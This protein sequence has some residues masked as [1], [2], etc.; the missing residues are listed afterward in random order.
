MPFAFRE[1]T[2]SGI[3]QTVEGTSAA[4]NE[5]TDVM[6]NEMGWILEDDRRAQAGS[7]NVTLTHKVVFNSD[8]GELGNSA[9]WYLTMTSGTSATT[10]QNTIGLQIHSAYDVGT[11]DTA[12]TGVETPLAH[13]SLTLPTDSNGIFNLWISGTKDSVIMVTNTLN[14]HAHAFI[15]KSKSFLS[16]DFEPYGLHISASNNVGLA[17]TAARSIIANPPVALQN[18]SEGELLAI[19]ITANNEPRAG[20]GQVAPI[21]TF[22][23]LVHSADDTSPTRRGMIGLAQNAWV[24]VNQTVGWLR[25]TVVTITGSNQTYLAFPDNT[26][27]LVMR[28]T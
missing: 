26:S 5:I 15:G 16:T 7:S 25:E 2:V 12:A 1:V 8:G 4:L 17:T 24:G 14:V 6:V 11:H 22:L 27:A 9:N 20:L 18:T 23:P 19:T 13:T 3:L 10:Q 21:F 28:R